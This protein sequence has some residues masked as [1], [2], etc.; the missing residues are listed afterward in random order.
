MNQ[1][2]D[3]MNG[4]ALTFPVPLNC[5]LFHL[6]SHNSIYLLFKFVL[7]RSLHFLTLTAVRRRAK[8]AIKLQQMDPLRLYA[9]LCVLNLTYVVCT[10]IYYTT[11]CTWL[12]V[13]SVD[14]RWERWGDGTNSKDSCYPCNVME[15]RNFLF[16]FPV[17]RISC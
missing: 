10:R 3:F 15:S 4:N 12:D 7:F 5:S 11:T 8:I 16:M 6:C 9:C 1:T 17:Y 2:K 13:S 14:V